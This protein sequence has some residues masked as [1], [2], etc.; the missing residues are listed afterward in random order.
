MEEKHDADGSERL[1]PRQEAFVREYLIDL[2]ATQ[3]AIRAGYSAATADVQGPRLLGNV[4]V[5]AAIEAGKKARA[6][7]TGIT[8]EKVLQHLFE[9]ATA[10][11]NELIQ[12]RREAC[13]SCWAEEGEDDGEKLEPQA[14]GGALK[15][16]RRRPDVSDAAPGREPN[17][18]CP[19]CGGE[20]EGRVF[21]ADTRHL[22][23]PARRLYAGVQVSRDGLKVNMRSQDGALALLF[24]HLGLSA[25][26]RSEHSGVGG[27]PIQTHATVD[28]LADMPREKREAMRKAMLAAMK[29]E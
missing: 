7:K 14:H 8:A 22:K 17:L 27:G 28:R 25:P 16:T 13:R 23:G 6:K 1:N 19:A 9:I 3:A 29:G 18:D 26:K 12:Y 24:D 21:L 4:R 2:N 5:A 11:P 20:G 10:D 15:R